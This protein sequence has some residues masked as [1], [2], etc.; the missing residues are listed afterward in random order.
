MYRVEIFT[1]EDGAFIASS[2]GYEFI[3]DAKAGGITPPDTFLASLGSCMGVCIR[4]YFQGLNIQLGDF[5]IMLEAEFS[6]EKPICFNKINVNI[7]FKDRQLDERRRQALLAF[8]KNCPIHNTL[9]S[10][11]EIQIN[12]V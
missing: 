2:K 1:R 5:K 7:D 3:I 10:N 11:P 6:K 12:I 8:V 4:K 9:K